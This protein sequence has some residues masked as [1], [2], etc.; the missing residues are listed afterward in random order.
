MYKQPM[1]TSVVRSGNRAAWWSVNF[2]SSQ[3]SMLKHM[4]FLILLRKE[5]AYA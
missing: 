2:A 1:T 3:L 4:F 5:Q